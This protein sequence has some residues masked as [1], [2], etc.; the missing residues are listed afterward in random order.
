[1]YRYYRNILLG[2]FFFLLLFFYP[3]STSMYMR[4]YLTFATTVF[5]LICCL[6]SYQN[7]LW[8]DIVSWLCIHPPVAVLMPTWDA[9]TEVFD[10]TISNDMWLILC[11]LLLR[12]TC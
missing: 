3:F 8:L 2:L 4:T 1:M 6:Q 5:H 10:R 7:I 11:F 12:L 9:G